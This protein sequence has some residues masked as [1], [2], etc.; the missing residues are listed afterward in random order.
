MVMSRSCVE[1]SVSGTIVSPAL[2]AVQLSADTPPI[3]SIKMIRHS[4]Q[5]P[6]SLESIS[7]HYGIS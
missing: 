6:D 3:R 7:V 4:V 5:V 2:N 1:N